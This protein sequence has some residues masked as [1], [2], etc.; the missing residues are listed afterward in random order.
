LA[1]GVSHDQEIEAEVR[2]WGLETIRQELEPLRAPF[3]IAD[4]LIEVA[5]EARRQA[6]AK[7]LTLS[8]TGDLDPRDLRVGDERLLRRILS[9]LLSNAVR[10]A[11]AGGIEVGLKLGT[12]D[13]EVIVATIDA[14]SAHGP[15]VRITLP[16]TRC[17][18]AGVEIQSGAREG[19]ARL[20]E[21]LAEFVTSSGARSAA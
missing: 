1:G 13:I 20:K 11:D 6:A 18:D 19:R 21:A 2:S 3:S 7:G 10:L 12:G 15:C 5:S 8:V 16:M 17:P 9:E 4:A 14:G